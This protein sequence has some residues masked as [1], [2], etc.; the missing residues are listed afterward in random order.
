[1]KLAIKFIDTV[2]PAPI[3]RLPP[4]TLVLE[5]ISGHQEVE[6]MNFRAVF[7][8]QDDVAERQCAEVLDEQGV[9]KSIPLLGKPL[10]PDLVEPPVERYADSRLLRVKHVDGW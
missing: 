8:A 5:R 7:E 9:A 6:F 10:G 3:L 1:M 4:P 2:Q